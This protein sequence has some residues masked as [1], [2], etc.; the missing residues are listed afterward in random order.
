MYTVLYDDGQTGST[1]LSRNLHWDVSKTQDAPR[2]S[3]LLL[4]EAPLSNHENCDVTEPKP[5]HKGRGRTVR[6]APTFGPT[7]KRTKQS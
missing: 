5:T 1:C 7:A 6:A 3:W 2:W 4:A